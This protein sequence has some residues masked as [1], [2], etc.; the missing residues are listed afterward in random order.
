VS[1][2][3]LKGWKCQNNTRVD[4]S[5]TLKAEK[6]GVLAKT[7]DLAKGL[8]TMS[9]EDPSKTERVTF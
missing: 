1:N 2:F 6:T 9:G 5:F 7:A 8:L 4:F 3:T